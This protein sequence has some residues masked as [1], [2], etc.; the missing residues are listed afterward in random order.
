M[1]GDLLVALRNHPE[2]TREILM[3]A[4]KGE[5][6]LGAETQLPVP[7]VALGRSGLGSSHQRIPPHRLV[8]GVGLVEDLEAGHP[9]LLMRVT[10]GGIGQHRRPGEVLAQT[11]PLPPPPF[12]ESW[13]WSQGLRAHR[14]SLLPFPP[15]TPPTPSART[16]SVPLSSLLAERLFYK[17]LTPGSFRPVDVSSREA[18]VSE[19]IEKEKGKLNQQQS[20]SRTSS[21]AGSDRGAPRRGSVDPGTANPS[22]TN[23]QPTPPPPRNLAP[24]VRPALSFAAAAKNDGSDKGDSGVEDT[25]KEAETKV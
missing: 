21:R 6:D 4:P 11:S 13:S 2:H 9:S 18:E 25:T 7:T 12:V 3:V 10:G 17:L 14:P 24:N 8:G 15:P 22:P 19:R 1:T 20:M 23:S 5:V 16:R